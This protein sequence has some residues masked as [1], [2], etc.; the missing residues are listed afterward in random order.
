MAQSCDRIV[1]TLRRSGATIDVAH[2]HRRATRFAVELREGGADLVG[3][4]EEDPAHALNR[5]W[6]LARR[7]HREVPYTHVVAFGGQIP[8]VAGPI[9]AAWLDLP[10]VTLLRGNDFDLGVFSPKRADVIRAALQSS[11]C[12]ATVS[13]EQASRVRA[14]HPSVPVVFTPNGIDH[15]G[16]R[17]LPEDVRRGRDWRAAQV[18]SG[19]RL[20]G[21]FGQLKQKKGALFFLETLAGSGLA[22]RFHLLV[23]GDIEPA[24]GEWLREHAA[25]LPVTT[26]PFCDR[27]ELLPYYAAVDLVAIPSF[28]D[29]MPNV[30][31]EAAALGKPLLVSDAGGMPDV[32]DSGSALLFEAGDAAGCRRA[33]MTASEVDATLL[34]GMAERARVRTLAE[35]DVS[36]EVARYLRVLS[37]VRSPPPHVVNG[38][39]TRKVEPA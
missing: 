5:L 33:L 11:A 30:L 27:F 13:S 19:R 15:E 28:Y 22:E 18:Q 29:G 23:V 35:F 34:A 36:H 31:L 21:I 32:V 4:F 6:T 12:I 9:F 14:L 10:L 39:V 16:W 38:Q 17:L 25:I 7:R 24:I 20:V 3:P 2:L 1:R 26:L 8:L 37:E